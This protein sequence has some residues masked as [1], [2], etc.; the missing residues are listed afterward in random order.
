MGR[1][2]FGSSTLLL[3]SKQPFRCIMASIVCV[4]V[5]QVV[6]LLTARR[7]KN[8][9]EN[10]DGE[11]G[12]G[13]AGAYEEEANFGKDA[14]SIPSPISVSRTTFFPCLLFPWPARFSFLCVLWGKWKESVWL[15]KRLPLGWSY[16]FPGKDLGHKTHIQ[17]T[18]H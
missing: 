9:V 18:Q 15:L 14:V 3:F 10:G 13:G 4:R 12:W 5:C 1:E 8:D 11:L 16:I 7:R 2:S 6:T 17:T